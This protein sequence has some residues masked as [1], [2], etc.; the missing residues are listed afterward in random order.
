MLSGP[1]QSRGVSY[2]FLLDPS[3][4]HEIYQAAKLAKDI[5]CRNFHMRPVGVP[6]DK[7]IER[8]YN[9]FGKESIEEF[10][11]QTEKARELE[12]NNFGVFG[13]THKF[14]DEL[15]I[16]ND[17]KQCYAIFMTAVFMP[18]SDKYS[19]FNLGLC[20]DRRG[21]DSL[22]IEN[23]NDIS[24]VKKFW[25]SEKHWGMFDKIRVDKCPRCTYMPHNEIYHHAVLKDNMS[26]D[27]I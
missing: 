10:R 9:P 1:E 4:A 24:E 8:K 21:D 16:L 2:K 3:N 13:V 19:K 26:Y 27:F 17:F 12:D 22:T 14:D 25:G 5:G 23:I 15:G 18:P 7:I 6:W 11:R 20:C